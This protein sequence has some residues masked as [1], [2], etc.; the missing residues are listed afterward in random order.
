[1]IS[2]AS[3]TT[4]YILQPSLLEKHRRTLNW[5]SATL[6]WQR[7]F[8]FFQKLLDQYA[9]KFTAVEDKKQIDHFQNLL[10]YYKNELIVDLRKKLRD[11]ETRLADMLQT[12]DETKTEYFKEHDAIM[13]ELESFN[14]AFT[15][16][17]ENLFGFI[18]RAM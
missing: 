5:L 9:S 7:E 8:N 17:K 4:N 1:M 2:A 10:I 11:H 12:K 6:L 16:Y 14:N 15:E 18:E 3:V 13:Q